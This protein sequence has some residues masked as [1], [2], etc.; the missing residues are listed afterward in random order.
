MA[1]DTAALGRRKQ[2]HKS[3][4]WRE[5]LAR[6]NAIQIGGKPGMVER[7]MFTEQLALML[8]TGSPLHSSLLTLARTT[9]SVPLAR[10]IQDVADGIDKGGSFAVAL[11]RTG[12][13][14]DVTYVNLISAGEKGGFLPE[15]LTQL[16]ETDRKRVELRNSVKT[17]LFYPAFLLLFS[18]AVVAFVMLVLFPKFA[19]LFE[20]IHDRLPTSTKVLMAI[21]DVMVN[22]WA[23]IPGA[24]A[25]GILALVFVLMRPATRLRIDRLKLTMPVV[26]EVIV[27]YYLLQTLRVLALSLEHG[28]NVLD[29][30]R[31]CREI[32]QNSYFRDFL[33]DTARRVELGEGIGS[34]FSKTDMLPEL[35]K[36]MIVTGDDTGNLAPV[37]KRVAGHYE[38]ELAKKIELISKLAEPLMLLLMGG[39]VGL[40]VSSLIL[41]IFQLSKAVH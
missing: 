25:A 6:L 19:P 37:M 28:V 21:S 39:F 41:P 5:W 30:I 16:Y 40:L 26:R 38:D 2:T 18:V 31:G 11:S 22:H 10:I 20:S 17:A 29:A 4:S 33:D 9:R 1:I 36:Q 34:G 12:G 32:V 27:R 14:F 13:L 3:C 15:V 7:M 8:E 35:V 24:L 23:W